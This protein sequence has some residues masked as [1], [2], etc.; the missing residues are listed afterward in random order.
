MKKWMK[1]FKFLAVFAMAFF[2]V[3][4]LP[5]RSE[6]AS[7]YKP[8]NLSNFAKVKVGSYYFWSETQSDYSDKVYVSRYADGSK[9]SLIYTTEKGTGA[10]QMLTNGTYI[11]YVQYVSGGT[12]KIYRCK[13]N[14]KSKVKYKTLNTG[15]GHGVTLL[16]IRSNKLYYSVFGNKGGKTEIFQLSVSK[17][18]QKQKSLKTAEIAGS[19]G[20]R[21]IY[22]H[23]SKSTTAFRVYDIKTK[24]TKTI[25]KSASEY[26]YYSQIHVI[27]D[28]VYYVTGNNGTYNLYKMNASGS[29]LKKLAS[30]MEQAPSDIG[31]I[32]SKSIWFKESANRWWRYDFATG[33]A[34]R[35]S[36]LAEYLE[37]IGQ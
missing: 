2:M 14:G 19:N 31:K 30:G 12:N 1:N 21:Y 17:K 23:S 18:N 36:G 22:L 32:T 8:V 34:T 7:T 29:G 20:Y 5:A 35:Y 16:A 13:M 9:A 27:S 15:V 10:G 25:K 11:W 6:A 24:K 28:K 33:E 3:L 26:V 37:A 4:A